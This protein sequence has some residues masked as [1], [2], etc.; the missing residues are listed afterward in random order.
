MGG[1]APARSAPAQR[2]APAAKPAPAKSATSFDDMDDD[3]PF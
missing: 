1:G 3:I 2:S